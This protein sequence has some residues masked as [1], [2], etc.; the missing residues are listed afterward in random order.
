MIKICEI[1]NSEFSAN[2]KVNG[3]RKTLYNRR[4]CL[5]CSP[6]GKHNTKILT[7]KAVYV[8]GMKQCTCCNELKP[9]TMF[10][11]NKKTKH[12]HCKSCLSNY[13][14]ARQRNLKAKAVQYKG[15]KCETCG[16]DKH[17]AAL[18]FHHIDPSKK[19]FT[20][21]GKSTV[22]FNT[23]KKE[24]DKCQLLC[25]NCHAI[26]HSSIPVTN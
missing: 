11:N 16:Y 23:I 5:Q 6:Y 4:Y 9:I 14:S 18:T 19:E 3:K 20:I 26:V 8:D 21:S 1:C 13:Y 24:L 15:G 25:R 17:Q 22:G 2:I 10:Y 7:N 12:S